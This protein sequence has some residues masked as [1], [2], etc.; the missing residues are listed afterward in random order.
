MAQV[1]EHLPSKHE[2]K[3]PV[4]SKKRERKEKGRIFESEFQGLC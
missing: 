1:V 4:P 2:V 3:I